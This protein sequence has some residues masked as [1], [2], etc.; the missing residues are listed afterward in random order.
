MTQAVTNLYKLSG[1]VRG[2]ARPGGYSVS[3]DDMDDPG[4][5]HA[6]DQR[7]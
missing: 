4:V 7:R 5:I 1:L 3:E 6:C 2:I